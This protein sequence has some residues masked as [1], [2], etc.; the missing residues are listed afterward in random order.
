MICHSHHI[1]LG[2]APQGSAII[3]T[4]P[5]DSQEEI[6]SRFLAPLIQMLPG[7]AI[8][9]RCIFTII[10]HIIQIG[11]TLLTSVSSLAAVN[12]WIR[13]RWAQSLIRTPVV[14]NSLR[15]I[16][17]N[18]FVNSLCVI[19]WCH[20]VFSLCVNSLWFPVTMIKTSL[21]QSGLLLLTEIN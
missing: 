2:S 8:V 19:Q 3:L 9:F 13:L 12:V 14:I 7:N 17:T 18:L 15:S 11:R 10:L 1:Y 6:I 5:F 16:D 21:N 4:W 20:V